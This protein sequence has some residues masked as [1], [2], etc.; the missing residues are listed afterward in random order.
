[1]KENL[2]IST[3]DRANDLIS[4]LYGEATE[5]E[6]R[7]FELHLKECQTCQ[8]EM[9]SLGQ[10]RDSISIW[11]DEA[12]SISLSPQVQG[13]SPRK[14]ALGAIRQFFDLSPLWLKGA[15]G[16]ATLVLC[17]L[18][19]LSFVPSGA[20]PSSNV[21]AT[22]GGKYTDDDLKRAVAEA[23]K[24]QSDTLESAT[25]EQVQTQPQPSQS[26][27]RLPPKRVITPSKSDTRW[28]KTPKPLSRSEREQL[29]SDLRLITTTDDE[30][31]NLL[32]D[33]INQ[34]F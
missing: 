2:E 33:K 12:L 10:V 29:A 16:F 25:T 17:V 6:S 31:L 13:L 4:L 1:M 28:A 11:K 3:C 8:L 23:L 14:S 22:P 27:K 9:V 32:S 19:A 21:S 7:N 18:A 20:K 24:K 34:E 30:G 26:P 15:V 5:I